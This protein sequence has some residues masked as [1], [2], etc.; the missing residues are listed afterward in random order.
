MAVVATALLSACNAD[1]S[2]TVEEPIPRHALTTAT[3]SDNPLLICDR[4]PFRAAVL[5]GEPVAEQGT[6]PSDEALRS[7]VVEDPD[8]PDEGWWLTYRGRDTAQYLVDNGSTTVEARLHPDAGGWKL[9]NAKVCDLVA[10]HG[11]AETGRWRLDPRAHPP[12]PDSR[13]LHLII[14]GT[15]C[16]SGRSPFGRIRPLLAQ[17]GTD[18]IELTVLLRPIDGGFQTCLGSASVRRTVVLDEPLGE[19]E[20]LDAAIYPPVAPPSRSEPT[21]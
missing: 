1:D 5:A 16:V 2:D 13:I 8:L 20:L 10:F 18:V 11:A 21:E 14:S 12:R 15:A 4:P 7:A 6:H 3:A 9:S 19:R 17:Y